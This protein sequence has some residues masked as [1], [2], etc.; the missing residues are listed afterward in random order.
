MEKPRC[1]GIK[2]SEEEDMIK[3][4]VIHNFQCVLL[5]LYFRETGTTQDSAQSFQYILRWMGASSF[6]S[7]LPDHITSHFS[8]LIGPM[9]LH[10]FYLFEGLLC[11]S[12][13]DERIYSGATILLWAVSQIFLHLSKTSNFDSRS[14]MPILCSK[15]YNQ[16]A[17]PKPKG[18]VN[19]THFRPF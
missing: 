8:C 19:P 12:F 4:K 6:A 11:S 18:N 3:L 5:W 9:Q 16:V 13:K 7:L 15:P 1:W 2:V 10:K 17:S 14:W